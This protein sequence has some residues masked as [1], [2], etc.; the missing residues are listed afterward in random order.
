MKIKFTYP[1]GKAWE[2]TLKT[3]VQKDLVE[4]CKRVQQRILSKPRRCASGNRV[5]VV[6]LDEVDEENMYDADIDALEQ[7]STGES[8][9]EARALGP[10]VTPKQLR[11]TFCSTGAC[12]IVVNTVQCYCGSNQCPADTTT[13]TTTGKL[14]LVFSSSVLQWSSSSSPTA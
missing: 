5:T 4:S 7:I 2:S 8:L 14:S 11:C 13:T 10:L 9:A 1:A 6:R 3:C 12:T